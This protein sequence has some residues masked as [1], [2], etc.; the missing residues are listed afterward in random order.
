ME[1]VFYE[2]LDLRKEGNRLSNLE[3][4]G[5]AMSDAGHEFGAGTPY[6]TDF[7]IL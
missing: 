2:K 1:E 3:H 6:G 5:Q 7:H 4:L